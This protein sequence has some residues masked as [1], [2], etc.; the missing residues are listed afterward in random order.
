MDKIKQYEQQ[1]QG[2]EIMFI[3]PS[4]STGGAERVI[5]TLIKY[6]DRSRFK[7]VLVILNEGSNPLDLKEI[8][9]EVEL[10]NLKIK[11]AR[12]S[13]ITLFN[14][15]LKRKPGTVLSTLGY[16]NEIVSFLLPVLPKSIKFIARESSIVSKR[17]ALNSNKKIHNWIYHRLIPRF[18]LI[19]C[20]SQ[21]MYEDLECEYKIPEKKMVIIDNPLDIE[22]IER[23]SKEMCKE[24]LS[25]NHNIIAVG[26]LK[27][28]K[29]YSLLILEAAES[30]LN[31]QY[32]I[33]GEGV[34]RHNLKEQIKDLGLED[35]VHLLGHKN[36]PWK[37]MA[38]A[39]EFWQK[40][41]F[42]GNS[43]AL[44]EW[45]ALRHLND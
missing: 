2:N 6:L 13:A 14:L 28:V 37:Y 32:F 42:E 23:R 24:L 27:L 3:M 8:G 12:Y 18:D 45:K 22:Y 29:N 30:P 31:H 41:E 25:E 40:S 38:A 34:E 16:V 44:K 15:I 9:C 33:I 43:N 5:V 21:E 20:Q 10:V 7:P 19:I 35:K 26:S 36:N 39:N 4:L 1:F 17:N 11:K